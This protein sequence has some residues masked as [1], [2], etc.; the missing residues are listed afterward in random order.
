MGPSFRV[1]QSRGKPIRNTPWAPC[2]I[3]TV[4]PS[5]LLRAPDA[6]ARRQAMVAF[7][8]DLRAVKKA[9]QISKV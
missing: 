2:I 4:H 3:A 8:K 9:M 1:T 5:S 7:E 6:E